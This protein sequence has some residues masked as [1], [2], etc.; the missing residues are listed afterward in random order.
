[1]SDISS[2]QFSVLDEK[3]NLTTNKAEVFPEGGV[4]FAGL[5]VVYTTTLISL[6]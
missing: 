3:F 1:M 4:L 6:L 2:N 5:D